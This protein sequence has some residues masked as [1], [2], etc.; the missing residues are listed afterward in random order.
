[1]PAGLPFVFVSAL[2]AGVF[3]DLVPDQTTLVWGLGVG[4]GF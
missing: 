3:V 1:M 4:R 2:A